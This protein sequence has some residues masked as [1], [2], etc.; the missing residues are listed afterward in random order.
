MLV[1][2]D[3]PEKNIAMVLIK[4]K[5]VAILPLSPELANTQDVDRP[6]YYLK[7]TC[8]IFTDYEQV[9]HFFLP[10]LSQISTNQP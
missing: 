8:E 4:R 2:L 1:S 5:P 9:L 3:P 6:V 10:V 7:A